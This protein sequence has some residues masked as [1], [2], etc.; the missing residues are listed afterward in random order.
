M[1]LELAH[2]EIARLTFEIETLKQQV[3]R[4]Q[5]DALQLRLRDSEAKRVQLS[6]SAHQQYH[7]WMKSRREAASLQAKLKACT[8]A[9]AGSSIVHEEPT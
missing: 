7:A 9:A 8:C 4:T 6:V 3:A 2:Q 5:I 1:E